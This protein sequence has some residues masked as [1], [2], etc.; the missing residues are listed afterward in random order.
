MCSPGVFHVR[1]RGAHARKHSGLVVGVGEGV[2]QVQGEGVVPERHPQRFHV[3]AV[4][5][6]HHDTLYDPHLRVG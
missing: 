1:W 2:L 4:L 3:T 5:V 6:A